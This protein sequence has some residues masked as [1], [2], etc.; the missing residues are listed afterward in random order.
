[1][2]EGQGQPLSVTCV[3]RVANVEPPLGDVGVG[4]AFA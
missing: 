2:N 1:M 3:V 4:L